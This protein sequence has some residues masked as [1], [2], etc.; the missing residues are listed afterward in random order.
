[1]HNSNDLSDGILTQTS[2]LENFELTAYLNSYFLFT[3]WLQTQVTN[4]ITTFTVDQ[5]NNKQIK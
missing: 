2:K 4:W 5:I 1:M 3:Q